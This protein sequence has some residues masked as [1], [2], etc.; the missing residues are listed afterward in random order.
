MSVRWSDEIKAEIRRKE[1]TWKDVLA[2]SDEEEKERY[3][4]AY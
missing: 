1:T 3:M 4:E 2:V